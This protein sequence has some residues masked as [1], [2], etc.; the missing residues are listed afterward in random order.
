[1]RPKKAYIPK[2][3]EPNL[4]KKNMFWNQHELGLQ[5]RV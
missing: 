1:M 2:T 5:P 4:K 3:T